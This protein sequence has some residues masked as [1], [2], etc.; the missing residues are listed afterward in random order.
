MAMAL[1]PHGESRQSKMHNADFL[2]RYVP[3]ITVPQNIRTHFPADTRPPPLFGSLHIPIKIKRSPNRGCI[4]KGP[5]RLFSFTFWLDSGLS[6][7]SKLFNNVSEGFKTHK[8]K[9]NK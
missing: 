1:P 5:L 9:Q 7:S 4:Y 3:L 2:L 8:R 6:V